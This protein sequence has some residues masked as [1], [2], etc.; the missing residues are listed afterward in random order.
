MMALL[1]AYGSGEVCDTAKFH[2][3]GGRAKPFFCGKIRHLMAKTS[4]CLPVP[5]RPHVFCP[6]DLNRL[7]G[8]PSPL[9]FP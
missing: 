3:R 1:L 2:A 4:P 6:G 9:R 5:Y 7:E 8:Q